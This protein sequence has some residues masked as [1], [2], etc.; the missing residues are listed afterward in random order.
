[1]T[2]QIR[3][4]A[5]LILE[6]KQIQIQLTSLLV[7]F[8]F[9][10]WGFLNWL[11]RFSRGKHTDWINELHELFSEFSQGYDR[12]RSADKVS[13][14]IL[15]GYLLSKWDTSSDYLQEVGKGADLEKPFK[16]IETGL[17]QARANRAKLALLTSIVEISWLAS[18]FV[19]RSDEVGIIRTANRLLT[20]G[21]YDECYLTVKEK[22]L[23]KIRFVYLEEVVERAAV[24]AIP[25]VVGFF[26]LETRTGAWLGFFLLLIMSTALPY[27]MFSKLLSD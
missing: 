21:K 27:Y 10:R 26:A 2:E 24:F 1:M 11:R 8:P 6:T 16:Q 4:S 25:T 19:Y 20:E 12:L 7:R 9:S 23:D 22:I 3:K 17:V 15:R 18:F 14:G 13:M 5:L